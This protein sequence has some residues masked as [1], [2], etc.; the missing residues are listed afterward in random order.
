MKKCLISWFALS[1]ICP[2]V[3]AAPSLVT[4]A[5][6]SPFNIPFTITSSGGTLTTAAWQGYLNTS[7]GSQ[8]CTDTPAG[9]STIL[10]GAFTVPAGSPTLYFNSAATRGPHVMCS[11]YG[12]GYYAMTLQ[13]PSSWSINGEACL[14]TS[15]CQ[16]F[17]CSGGVITGLSAPNSGLSVTCN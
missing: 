8:N 9:G 12:D 15:G 5:N 17:I 7:Q 4:T 14:T 6:I 11:S 1:L 13:G 2:I 10:V 3:S 16:G